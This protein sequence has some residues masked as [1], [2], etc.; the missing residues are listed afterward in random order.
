LPILDF[1]PL[2]GLSEPFL[3]SFVAC[4]WK[5][6]KILVSPWLSLCNQPMLV[7]IIT[8]SVP[9]RGLGETVTKQLWRGTA[10]YTCPPQ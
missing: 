5:E 6:K 1:S 9:G 2:I 4:K 10:V 8:G 3:C 7:R